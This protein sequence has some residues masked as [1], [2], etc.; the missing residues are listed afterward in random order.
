MTR[1]HPKQLRGCALDAWRDEQMHSLLDG[2]AQRKAPAGEGSGRSAMK[3]IT[4]GGREY[5]YKPAPI[6]LAAGYEPAWL[7]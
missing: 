5:K 3:T 7:R 6:T 1:Y 2:R 4:I